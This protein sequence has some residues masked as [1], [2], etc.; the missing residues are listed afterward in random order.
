M[1]PTTHFTLHVYAY[2]FQSEVVFVP[3]EPV[4]FLR[5]RYLTSRSLGRPLYNAK[6]FISIT[7][8]NYIPNKTERDGH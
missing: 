4:G 5:N 7:E 6:L 8:S 1:Y 3:L 2:E